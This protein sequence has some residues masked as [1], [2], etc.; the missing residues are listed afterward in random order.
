MC[1]LSFVFVCVC[2]NI[3]YFS[4]IQQ[5]NRYSMAYQLKF[6][7]KQLK[8]IAVD[9]DGTLLR[10][11]K[12]ISE[13]DMATLEMLGREGVIRVAATGR[14][15]HKVEEVLMAG[16]PIDYVVFSSGAGI[17]NWNEKKLLHSEQFAPQVAANVCR[18]L[19]EENFN[20]FVYQ[21]IPHNNLFLYHKGAGNCVEFSNY[22][23]R[24]KGDFSVLPDCSHV[25]ESGQFMAIVPNNDS[26]F[27]QLKND[28][29]AD[30]D[31]VRVIRATSP[32]N[33]KFTWIEIFP[34]AVSKGH[35]LKWL[36]DK[37][38]LRYSETVGIGNDFNDLDM[39][40]FV[41]H[42]F[43]LKNGV[44]ALKLKFQSV[45]FTNNENGFSAVVQSL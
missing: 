7:N 10:D 45:D 34:E 3:S 23:E 41:G 16:T 12:T 18:H 37:L 6:R 42:P 21:P 36:C 19:Y 5:T 2:N 40:E 27:E 8:L 31:G 25:C 26:L 28:I 4:S 33:D 32:V 1:V 39:F 15:M 38:E 43:L 35:G 29:H 13:V 14:S 20:F 22:L 11:D 30:C 9:L 17:F 24:H 44:E